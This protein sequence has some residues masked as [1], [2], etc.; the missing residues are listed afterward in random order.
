MK[1]SPV[2]ML[3]LIVALFAA[4]CSKGNVFELS[5]GQ[6]FDDPSETLISDVPLKDCSEP[7][8]NE[9]YAVFNVTEASLPGSQTMLEGCLDRFDAAIGAPYATSIYDFA[10]FTP[11][12]DS[13][14]EGDRE[15]VC[16][17][18]VYGVPEKM[19]SSILGAAK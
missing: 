3:A 12:A 4:G 16:Y 1:L 11:T 2:V 14:K 9:V 19:T 7:H 5:V 6:C 13:W 15:V 17:G 8:D 18:F 10:A